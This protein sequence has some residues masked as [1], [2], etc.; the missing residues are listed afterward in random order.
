MWPL[1]SIYVLSMHEGVGKEVG[2]GVFSFC[3]KGLE[4]KNN[5]HQVFAGGG[6]W[7]AEG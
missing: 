6:F 4:A 2:V 7:G 5:C 3:F 1:L